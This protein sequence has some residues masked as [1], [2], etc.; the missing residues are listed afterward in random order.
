LKPPSGAGDPL[1]LERRRVGSMQNWSYLVG[2][3]AARKC[4]VVDPA[5]EVDAILG[6]AQ[7]DGMEVVGALVTHW[8]PDHVGGDLFGHDI[9]GLRAL[10]ERKSVPIHV[11]RAELEGVAQVTGVSRKDLVGHDAGDVV[12]VG[13][14]PIRLLHTP[15]HTPGSQCFLC[16]GHLISGDTLFIRGCGRVDLPGGDPEQMWKSLNQVLRRLPPETKLH[17][18]HHYGPID[19]STIGE[20]IRENPYLKVPRLE[21]WLGMMGRGF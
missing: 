12:E 21:D 15:G 14:V 17:P 19:D 3:R 8:H 2:S 18:G 9:E 10:L 16:H 11:Q 4:L 6:Q 5:W 13:D 20:E 7:R 1:Y